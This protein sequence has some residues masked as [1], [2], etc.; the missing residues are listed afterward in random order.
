MSS[1]RS[2]SI[3]ILIG[4]LLAAGILIFAF[5]ESLLAYLSAK[6]FGEDNATQEVT[7]EASPSSL[8]EI[9]ILENQVFNHLSNRVLYFNFDKVGKPVLNQELG[10]NLQAP[11]WQAVYLGNSNPFPVKKKDADN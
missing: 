9:K 6:V 4:L 1:R 3:Y 7:L 8:M 10:A 5:K 11:L 2:S